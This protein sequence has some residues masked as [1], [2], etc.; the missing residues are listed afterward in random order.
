MP[1]KFTDERI[2]DA[3][4]P[5]V[6][7]DAFRA[8]AAFAGIHEFKFDDTYTPEVEGWET[9]DGGDVAIVE[10][11]GI[12]NREDERWDDGITGWLNGVGPI[13]PESKTAKWS[14]LSASWDDG[15]VIWS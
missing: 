5:N 7:E 15:V 4:G 14:D 8:Y 3:S 1:L 2:N 9:D 11:T 6:I 13:A 10:R 12:W